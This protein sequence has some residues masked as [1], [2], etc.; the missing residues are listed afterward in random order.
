MQIN[1]KSK[2]MNPYDHKAKPDFDHEMMRC[3]VD[4]AGRF[5]FVSPALSWVLGR[6]ISVLL[7]QP[8]AD[9]CLAVDHDNDVM[10]LTSGFYETALSRHNRDPLLIETR[11]DKVSFGQNENYTVFWF[12]PARQGKKRLAYEY[13]DFAKQL[14]ENLVRKTQNIAQPPAEQ[15][16]EIGTSD[17]ELRHFL[18]LTNDLLAVYTIKGAFVRVNPTFNRVLGYPDSELKFLDF[19]DLIY[20]DDRE[21]ARLQI[22]RIMDSPLYVEVK[23]DFT[24]RALCKD[25]SHRFMEWVCKSS[26]GYIYIVGRDVTAI[27]NHEDEL[28]RREALLMEAQKIAKMG[29]WYWVNG[30]KEMQWSDQIYNIFGVTKHKFLPSMENVNALL[31]KRDINRIYQAFDMALAEK[32][33][34]TLEFRLRHPL[35]GLRYIRC[36]GKCELDPKSG[37]V[38]ALFGIMQDITE[39]TLHERA[40]REAKEAAESAYASK[41]RFLANMSHELRTPLNAIIGFS[42]MMQRQLL[43]PLGNPRYVDYIGG[44]LESGEHLLSLIND[45]LDMSKIEVGKYEIFAEE[46]NIGKIIRLAIHMMEGR[47]HESQVKLISNDIADDIQIKADRRAIMQILLNLLSNAVKFTKAGGHI[48]VKCY[49]DLMNVMI[50]IKDTGIGIP[51]DKID[52][53]MLPFEQVDSELTRHHEG[54]GLGLAITKDLVELHGGTITLESEEGKGTTVIVSLPEIAL[55]QIPANSDD[56]NNALAV[57]SKRPY[58]KTEAD[59]QPAPVRF[60]TD[61]IG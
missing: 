26:G 11:I 29:H 37:E 44:I 32:K 4:G 56:E 60:K 12:D 35:G 13:D 58:E 15:A 41:T 3:V 52:V 10:H 2:N 18:N 8:I 20:P 17:S 7:G 22:K 30:S 33:D 16:R 6:D 47:A 34:Y 46:L 50:E 23:I 1:I 36:E 61:I 9:H 53:V 49:R 51:K 54:S 24:S 55:A 21:K 57:S 5:V 59:F 45:I 25:G 28:E 43:G 40:L 31:F 39:R 14:T 48:E 27:K 19:T 38:L 42:A